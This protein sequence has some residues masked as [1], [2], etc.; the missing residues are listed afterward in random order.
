MLLG[1]A[2]LGLPACQMLGPHGES[3]LVFPEPGP[4]W[5][6]HVGQLRY[7]TPQ[8]AVIGETVVSREGASEFQL[9]FMTGPG[10]P[11]MRLREE[12]Q[13]VLAEGLFAR[14]RWEGRP[15]RA[16]RLSGWVALREVFAAL[17]RPGSRAREAHSPEGSSV[18]WSARAE[19]SGQRL[20]R[21]EASFPRT[22]ER[23]IFVFPR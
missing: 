6:T 18:P 4:A 1:S 23:F 22:R 2:L 10:V 17:D 16:G 19:Y 14:G 21:L 3:R 20:E 9:D 15:G 11:L 12:G 5:Q 13:T 7:V 8:R